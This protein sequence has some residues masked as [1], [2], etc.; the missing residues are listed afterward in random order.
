MNLQLVF[1]GGIR[2]EYNI[3]LWC[4]LLKKSHLEYDLSVVNVPGA[5]GT[6]SEAVFFGH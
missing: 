4:L 3:V 5:I 2:S 1:T 6:S